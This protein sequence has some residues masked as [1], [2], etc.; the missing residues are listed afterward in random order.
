MAAY[1]P[2]PALFERQLASIRT[3]S[4]DDFRVIICADGGQAEVRALVARLTDADRRFSVIG[5]DDR[6]GFYRNFERALSAVPSHAAWVALSDQ[7]DFWHERKL[8]LMLPH[9]DRASMVAA[10]ARVVRY[11]DGA[12]LSP[13][14]R[15]RNVAVA[16]LPVFNQFTG[17]MSVFRRGILDLA[18]PFPVS[19]SPARVH[20]Q[21]LALC[22]AVTDEALV[23][24]DLVQDYVQH[25]GNVLGETADARLRPLASWHRLR[26]R[27]R[28]EHG[29]ASPRGLA[30]AAF[31]AS[32]GW[33]E[34]MV[35]TLAERLP[36]NQSARQLGSLYGRRRSLFRVAAHLGRSVISGN[37]PLRNAIVYLAGSALRPLARRRVR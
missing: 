11:P 9:L 27:V 34:T 37:V 4:V 22:A 8:E 18:L 13:N 1:R 26:D 36:A 21:W 30:A 24:P 3:Q 6:L 32:A 14:T 5:A 2:D 10:Q 19:D 29:S 25:G 28:E 20:D 31:A 7:D 17:G 35:E 15:R 23:I 12:I 16:D 33:A